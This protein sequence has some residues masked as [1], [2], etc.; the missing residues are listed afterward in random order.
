MHLLFSVLVRNSLIPTNAHNIQEQKFNETEH[1][2][3]CFTIYPN[4][5]RTTLLRMCC[6][7][8]LMTH[9]HMNYEMI[10]YGDDPISR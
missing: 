3:L 8:G 1:F 6:L 5:M 10:R 4:I 7:A 9:L 2:L